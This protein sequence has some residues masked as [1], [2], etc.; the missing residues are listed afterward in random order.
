MNQTTANSRVL[1]VLGMHRSGTSLLASVLKDHGVPM[2]RELLGP[3]KGNPHGHYEDRAIL[4]FHERILA[5]VRA[6]TGRVFD[7]GSMVADPEAIELLPEEVEE[8]ARL[9]EERRK[10]GLWGWKDPRT[11]LFLNFWREQVG[12]FRSIIIYRH[13]LEVY[14]SF[15][16]RG[17]NYD[18]LV[19]PEQ[20]IRAYGVYNRELL[21]LH[22]GDPGRHLVLNANMV[23]QDSACFAR[24]LQGF[25][26]M[27]FSEETIARRFH[28]KDFH[29]LAVSESLHRMFAAAFPEEAGVFEA[30]QERAAQ[31]F[32]LTPSTEEDASV[33]QWEKSIVALGKELPREARQSLFG[34]VEFA[35]SRMNWR[36]LREVREAIAADLRRMLAW[37]RQEH[38]RVVAGWMA[39]KKI[40]DALEE[41]NK[42]IRDN[43]DAHSRKAQEVWK[44]LTKVGKSW[45]KQRD[46][47]NEWHEKIKEQDAAL[48][49][50]QKRIQELEAE[51]AAAQSDR[52]SNP[53]EAMQ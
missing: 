19:Y 22:D 46:L 33:R 36:E 53:P 49:Q 16:R 47:L 38:E 27:Q 44:E 30:L 9:V 52:S 37:D 26:G 31:P 18:Q 4:E 2:G 12:G 43:W 51:L 42:A 41:R 32:P 23:F 40:I 25:I 34:V 35:A 21:E 13:P 11:C 5:R 1:L 48:E 15:L 6:E 45:E 3:S 20:L 29:G 14:F 7:N 8:G 17:N 24:E 10:P 50:Q 28:R 39:Q